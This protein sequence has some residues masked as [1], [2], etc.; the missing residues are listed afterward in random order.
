MLGNAYDWDTLTY[1]EGMGAPKFLKK[2]AKAVKKTVA[3]PVKAVV[4]APLKAVAKVPLRKVVKVAAVGLVPGVA[5]AKI[6]KKVAPKK[7]TKLATRAVKAVAKSPIKTLAKVAVAPHLLAYKATKAALKS[8]VGK[9]LAVGL[10]PGVGAV[11]SAKKAKKIFFK[12]APPAVAAATGQTENVEVP[13][14]TVEQI[15][16]LPEGSV[17][18]SQAGLT[19]AAEGRRAAGGAAAGG[20][21]GGGGDGEEAVEVASSALVSQGMPAEVAEAM[22]DTAKA[23]AKKIFGLPR[24][25]VI[26]GGVAAA[27]GLGFLMFRR[28]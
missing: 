3:K 15:Y 19:L 23:D 9:V 26:G 18:E 5:T 17:S 10:V 6:L 12:K 16:N 11:M 22:E 28:R 4:R 20:G 13:A 25:V 8:P 2:A 24:M 27:V 7:V 1:G 21:G 14:A